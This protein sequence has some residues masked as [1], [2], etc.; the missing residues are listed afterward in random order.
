MQRW[1]VGLAANEE[2]VLS[3]G[4]RTL[5]MQRTALLIKGRPK[6]VVRHVGKIRLRVGGNGR[7]RV[8]GL[9]AVVV[10]EQVLARCVVRCV[11]L[12]VIGTV[13]EVDGIDDVCCILDVI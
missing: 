7:M 2:S 4:E 1:M 12:K 3:F 10:A 11:F 13:R 5:F 6:G 8:D 9:G